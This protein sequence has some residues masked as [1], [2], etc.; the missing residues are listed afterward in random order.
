MEGLREKEREKKRRQVGL[1]GGLEVA[2]SF[3]APLTLSRSFVRTRFP[4]GLRS[5]T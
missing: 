5:G 3:E 1:L 2:A 4:D